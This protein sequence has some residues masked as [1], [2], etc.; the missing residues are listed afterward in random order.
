MSA[1][2]ENPEESPVKNM[3]DELAKHRD[4]LVALARRFAP[5]EAEDLVQDVFLKALPNLRSLRDPNALWSWLVRILD[6]E[7]RRRGRKR[8]PEN[9][10]P[11]NHPEPVDASA[12]RRMEEVDGHEALNSEIRSRL[13]EGLAKAIL[14]Q[15]NNDWDKERS[16]TELRKDPRYLDR[17]NQ[18]LREMIKER[19]LERLEELRQAHL[20]YCRN[21]GEE[22][23]AAIEKAATN[24]LLSSINPMGSVP[25]SLMLISVQYRLEELIDEN[26]ERAKME[27][28]WFEF[29]CKQACGYAAAT[30]WCGPELRELGLDS[31]AE[32]AEMC[33]RRAVSRYFFNFLWD[34]IPFAQ[35]WDDDTRELGV[36]P[37][38]VEVRYGPHNEVIA[39]YYEIEISDDSGALLP[40]EQA[41][42]RAGVVELLFPGDPGWTPDDDA[43]EASE[44]DTAV[45]S[46]EPGRS[47]ACPPSQPETTS[48]DTVSAPDAHRGDPASQRVKRRIAFVKMLVG[49]QHGEDGTNGERSE[50]P[51]KST[52]GPRVRIGVLSPYFSPPTA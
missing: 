19:D 20:A 28:D 35:M 23:A 10:D 34:Q 41:P 12:G 21:P 24:Q 51:S 44:Q 29:V 49:V 4:R 42:H 31:D 13:P 30:Y 26:A 40:P 8:R 37:A 48:G 18:R 45:G 14:A 16:A 50:E 47:G 25:Y 46:P 39:M 22:T 11:D 2:T 17:A 7:L 1:D 3:A 6:R 33:F 32:A 15:I 52:P 38:D 5:N 27:P 9:F 36:E 43:E